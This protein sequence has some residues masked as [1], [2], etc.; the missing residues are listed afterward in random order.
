ML[1]EN[2]FHRINVQMNVQDETM[3]RMFPKRNKNY[4][5]FIEEKMNF[6]DDLQ[7]KPKLELQFKNL[8]LLMNMPQTKIIRLIPVLSTVL[9]PFRFTTVSALLSF[10][11]VGGNQSVLAEVKKAAIKNDTLFIPPV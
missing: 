7:F 10:R 1:K 9:L 11:V 4:M 6:T 8:A 5:R 2:A 3:V